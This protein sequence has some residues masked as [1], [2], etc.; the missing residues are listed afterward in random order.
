MALTKQKIIDE[1]T[2]IGADYNSFKTYVSNRLNGTIKMSQTERE[3]F[4]DTDGTFR[5]EDAYYSTANLAWLVLKSQKRTIL[6]IPSILGLLLPED[7][8]YLAESIFT[9]VVFFVKNRTT[10][11]KITGSQIQT[12][13]WSFDENTS[14]VVIDNDTFGNFA[15]NAI[16]G[17]Q[18]D[19]YQIVLDNDKQLFK[20]NAYGE[21]VVVGD[22]DDDIVKAG[23]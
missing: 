4:L 5:E 14:R 6:R 10:Y 8:E 12:P 19:K 20:M 18:L 13:N 7:K 2:M 1:L 21:Y 15:K 9:Q 22:I 16:K 23:I 3:Q 11:E 17:A